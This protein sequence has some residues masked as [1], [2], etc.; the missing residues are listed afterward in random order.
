MGKPPYVLFTLVPAREIEAPGG[1]IALP[2][3]T[4]PLGGPLT[5]T[6]RF[7]QAPRKQK[8]MG[9]LLTKDGMKHQGTRR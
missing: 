7:Q 5:R 4:T 1:V 6:S 8:Q 2:H 3:C 9:D